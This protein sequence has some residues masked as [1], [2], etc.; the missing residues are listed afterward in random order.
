MYCNLSRGPDF[1]LYV[2]TSPARGPTPVFADT[3]IRPLDLVTY[4]AFPKS[5][6]RHLLAVSGSNTI[7]ADEVNN[8]RQ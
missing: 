5:I 1:V 4:R 3:W 2:C 6:L 8:Y 7:G